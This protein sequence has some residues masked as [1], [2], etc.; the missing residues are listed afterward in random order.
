M[1]K[2]IYISACLFLI[3]TFAAW[4]GGEADGTGERPLLRAGMD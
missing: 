3:A 1:K 2:I 4:G